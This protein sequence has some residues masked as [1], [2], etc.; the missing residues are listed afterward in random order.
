MRRVI[1]ACG[2]AALLLLAAESVAQTASDSAAIRATAMDYIEGW[3]TGDG[4][5]MERALHPDLVR[6]A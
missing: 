1:I 2:A 6:H 4:D 3:Y 5:R